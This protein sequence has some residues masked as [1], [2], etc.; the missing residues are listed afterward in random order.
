[1]AVIQV[2]GSGVTSTST[3]NKTG[4]FKGALDSSIGSNLLN[5]LSAARGSDIIGQSFATGI[6]GGIVKSVSAGVLAYQAKTKY[7]IRRVS[8]TIGGVANTILLSG[9]SNKLKRS[10]HK[11][12]ATIQTWR[13]TTAMR[14]GYYD[15]VNGT[16]TTPPTNGTDSIASDDAA[17]PTRAIP[18][19]LTYKYAKPLPVM[20]DYSARVG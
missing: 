19:E 11:I 1:M 20:A 3:N 18:G 17:N 6:A 14:A 8:T 2:N 15:M 4:R 7:V 9:A 5:G 16:F 12:G 13:I 10:I